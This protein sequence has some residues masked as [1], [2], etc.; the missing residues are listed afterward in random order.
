MA[1]IECRQIWRKV[2]DGLGKG[3]DLV[4]CFPDGL[5]RVTQEV[6]NEHFGKSVVSGQRFEFFPS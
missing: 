6:L 5:R 3:E 1:G 4:T 2:N